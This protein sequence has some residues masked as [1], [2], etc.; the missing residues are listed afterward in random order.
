MPSYRN[1]CEFVRDLE[2]RGE[3]IRVRAPVDPELEVTE[4]VDR[5]SKGPVE[6]NKALLFERV[7]GASVPLLINAF[8]S[9]QRM[10]L[11]LN[12]STLDDLT[13]NLSA[14]IDLKLPQG[15]SATVQRAGD[16][17]GVLSAIGL[18]PKRVK[19][20][21]CQEIVF[22]DGAELERALDELPILKCWPLDGGRYITLPQVITRDPLTGVRNVGMY[23]LQVRSPRTLMMH[24]QRHKGGAEHQRVAQEARKPTIP[25]A[26]A[27]GGDP[28][29]M[30]CASAPLP[31]NI[32]E[33]LLA[34]YLRGQ[35]VAFTPCITQPIEAPAEA[36]IVIEG[37]VDPNEQDIEGPFGDHTGFYTPPDTFPVFHITAVTRRR[38]AIYPAT[39]VGKPPMEDYWM[40]KATERLFLPLLRLFLGEV[41]DYNMPAE[42]VF[43][44]LVIVSIRKR[45][46]GHPQ[47]VMFGIWGLGLM[48]LSKA[49]VVV[50]HDVNVHDLREVA[51]R[52]LGNVDWKRDVTVVEGPVDQLDHSS[53]RDSFGGKIGIDATAKGPADGHPR[54]WPTEISMSPE[55]IER[56]NRRWSEYGLP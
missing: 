8:G 26:I 50:D 13:R 29:S 52:V 2:Q 47:K 20:A 11:A 38:D 27:L 44:N 30:W 16:L 36:D 35:P 40:G 32:D 49:I 43:H 54:G 48:M 42:G 55:I 9:A 14:V 12:V 37:Y 17:L 18:K 1:L 19:H 34:G 28:S 6:R 21:P 23:R 7:K 41:V 22:S 15:L 10:A 5:V 46:P 39:V 53:V 24:W 56:V 51:W 4:I 3:L 45:F 33:Y 31:P 25:C